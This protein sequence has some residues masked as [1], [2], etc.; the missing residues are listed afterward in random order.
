M[1]ARLP[2]LVLEHLLATLKGCKR[3]SGGCSC[4]SKAAWHIFLVGRRYKTVWMLYDPLIRP[5][6]ADTPK[7]A[8]MRQADGPSQGKRAL[9]MIEKLWFLLEPISP[10]TGRCSNTQKTN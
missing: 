5:A 9:T 10:L 2:K 8:K 6:Q 4:K 3:M 7:A 1:L